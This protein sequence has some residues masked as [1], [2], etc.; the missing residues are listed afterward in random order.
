LVRDRKLR[1]FDGMGGGVYNF[2]ASSITDRRTSVYRRK[3]EFFTDCIGTG[4]TGI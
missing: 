3:R 4:H 1:W 2:H